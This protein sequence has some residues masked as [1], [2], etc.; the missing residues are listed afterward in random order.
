MS[1]KI[2]EIESEFIPAIPAVETT[3]TVSAAAPVPVAERREPGFGVEPV[4]APRDRGADMRVEKSPARAEVP[5]PARGDRAQKTRRSWISPLFALVV[6]AAMAAGAW[7]FI[8]G[9]SQTSDRQP[10]PG[11]Q[12]QPQQ[13]GP[14]EPA[15]TIGGAEDFADWIT[16]FDPT[17][18][19]TVTAPGDS[20]AEVDEE[21]GRSFMRISS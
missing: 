3:R 11:P 18:P 5:A 7:W 10:A 20:R 13:S 15:P 19:T 21:D 2:T 14:S 1:A 16:V 12:P 9:S 4:V 17:D 6:F 8:G